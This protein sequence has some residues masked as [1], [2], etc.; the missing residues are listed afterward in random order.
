MP[1]RNFLNLIKNMFLKI[2]STLHTQEDNYN[3]KKGR[4]ENVKED[5][6]IIKYG[7]MD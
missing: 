5:I 1:D 7:R 4:H 2:Y 6:K 3:L